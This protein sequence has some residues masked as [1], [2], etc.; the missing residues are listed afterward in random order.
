[1]HV[2]G[3]LEHRAVGGEMNRLPLADRDHGEVRRLLL[4][5]AG[6]ART[7]TVA[8]AG[9]AGAQ[10]AKVKS[11]TPARHRSSSTT[12]T[13]ATD[14]P[15]G[16]AEGPRGLGGARRVPGTTRASGRPLSLR[17]LRFPSDEWR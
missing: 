15:G 4:G 17:L 5:V 3:T 8:V 11:R 14:V 16:E 1:M 12:G 10:A 13:D 6:T 9:A 2:S 7:G